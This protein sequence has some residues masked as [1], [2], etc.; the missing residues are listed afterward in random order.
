MVFSHS[1]QLFIKKV[2][3]PF[4]FSYYVFKDTYVLSVSTI[5][6]LIGF[7]ADEIEN[8]ETKN[9]LI[10]AGVLRPK[11]SKNLAVK[12]EKPIPTDHHEVAM[13]QSE[14]NN[15]YKWGNPNLTPFSEDFGIPTEEESNTST[16]GNLLVTEDLESV[17]I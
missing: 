17:V 13:L 6:Q 5:F 12:T 14:M 1:H 16:I 8:E 7:N 2:A 10:E 3:N 15:K 9:A 4:T 11:G